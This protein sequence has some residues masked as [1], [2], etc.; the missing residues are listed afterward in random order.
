MIALE[1]VSKHYHPDIKALQD[2][3]VRIE[4][5]EFVFLVG[6]SGAGKS[7]LVKLLTADERK[8]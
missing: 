1:G 7:T 5:G 2:I 8:T 4:P 6:M 3:N